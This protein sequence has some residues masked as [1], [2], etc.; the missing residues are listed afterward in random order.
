M[1]QKVMAI[2]AIVA[3]ITSLLVIVPSIVCATDPIT[4]GIPIDVDPYYKSLTGE[5]A[6]AKIQADT[7]SASAELAEATASFAATGGAAAGVGDVR[8]LYA[9]GWRQFTLLK[10]GGNAEIWL[11]ND[12]S[13]LPGDPRPYPVVTEEQIDYLFNE[14]NNV[15]YPG[16]TNYFGFTD[17]RYGTGGLFASWGYDWYQTDNPQRVMILV[18]N[19]ID[20]SYND[21]DFPFYIAGYFW[22]DMNDLYGDRNIIHIDTHDWE[23]RLGPGV[24]NPHL[25]ELITAHEY[26]HAIHYDH[27]PDEAAWIDEGMA[28]LAPF[29]IGYGHARRHL[30]Y[31]M[32][33]HRTQ[34]TDWG[35]GLEDY[36]ASY[37][38]QLYLLEN[39][40]GASFTQALLDEQEN[41]IKGIENVLTAFGY[42]VSFNDIYRDWTLANYLDDT[43]LTG[44][45]GGKLGYSNLEIPSE[46]TVGRSI[47]WSVDNFYGSDNQGALPIPRY[48]GGHKSHTV[49]WPAGVLPPYA[50][51]YLTYQG[52]QPKMI[53]TFS[54]D[55]QSGMRAHSG[56]YQLWGGKGDLLFNTATMTA[57]V[58]LG[59]NA[60][61]EFW[62]NYQIEQYWDFGFVQIS[63]DGGATWTS[64]QNQ[65]TTDE[66]DPAA[67]HD[68]V[69][70]LPGFTGSSGGWVPELFDLSSYAGQIVLLRFLFV[71]DW[72]YTEGGFYVDDILVTDDSGTLL[73][74]DLESGGGNWS[75]GG[76]EYT[77]GMIDNDWGL[78]FINPIYKK[79]KFSRY[80]IRDDHIVVNGAYQRDRTTLNTLNLN[81]DVVTIVLSNHLPEEKS[82]QSNYTLLVEKDDIRDRT[83]YSAILMSDSSYNSNLSIQSQLASTSSDNLYFPVSLQFGTGNI[84][85]IS[86]NNLWILQNPFSYN[87][88][89]NIPYTAE[90]FYQLYLSNLWSYQNSINLNVGRYVP[91]DFQY[92]NYNYNFLFQ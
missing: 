13:Y 88:V 22:P 69:A 5:T 19:I 38:F 75:L 24:S 27:D 47:Q 85:Q 6:L 92:S 2:F 43:A 65:D 78:T 77:T 34:L 21:P 58:T 41:G 39:F 86:G 20:D 61:L 23:N 18:F 40:G 8:V 57:P 42:D 14:F 46:D 81:Q 48:W 60:K 89:G 67:H 82:F 12:L 66:H 7:A 25:V 71:T 80:E 44:R 4:T 73:S 50:P 76:W 32:V 59:S 16:N 53:S 36:G 30:E 87:I 62:T 51:M 55:N 37:L 9:D 11:A 90:N 70:N 72:V 29:L 33:F 68:V 17:D 64:L 52:L 26:E 74:D 83:F 79:G 28:D 49:Q 15:I 10:I 45:S 56:N 1:K 54:G 3:F 84:D 31:Y 91:F 63:T 35:G